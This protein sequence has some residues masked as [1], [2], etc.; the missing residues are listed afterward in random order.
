[1]SLSEIDQK[2]KGLADFL[3]ESRAQSP[4]ILK[5][6]GE[7]TIADAMVIVTAASKRQAQ[8]LAQGVVE[9][10]K[11]NDQQYLHMEG[12]E[13]GEWILVDANDLLVNIFLPDTRD[14][15]RLEDLVRQAPKKEN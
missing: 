13:T 6:T 2:L 1:M 9:W 12:Y 3:E 11:K 15:Y 8:G 14:L 4:I 5:L 10:C 7:N